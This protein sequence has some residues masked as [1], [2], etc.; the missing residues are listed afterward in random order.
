MNQTVSWVR[1]T[2]TFKSLS[3]RISSDHVEHGTQ[4]VPKNQVST[5]HTRSGISVCIASS[6]NSRKKR[7]HLSLSC[8]AFSKQGPSIYYV[9]KKASWAGRFRK[10]QFLLLYV[11]MYSCWHTGWVGSEKSTKIFRHNIWMAPK[12]KRRNKC[13][14]EQQVM[15]LICGHN[16]HS[17]NAKD[18]GC[19]YFFLALKRVYTKW[20]LIN[21][22][23]LFSSVLVLLSFH[24]IGRPNDLIL[25]KV[26][27]L[28]K[29]KRFVFFKPR[30]FVIW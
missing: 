18:F 7:F 26:A 5:V 16:G 29:L 30:L 20:Q 3:E 24:E 2:A 23:N 27:V 19:S 6:Q 21:F 28:K 13:V 11:V 4:S 22:E 25:Q 10:C 17:Q 1:I 15:D 12:E 9:R 14:T 8:C